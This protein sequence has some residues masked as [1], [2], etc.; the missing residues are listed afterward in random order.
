MAWFLRHWTA[1]LV[2]VVLAAWA[3]LY[4]PGTP[5]YA[6]FQ[7]KQ[8]IDARDGSRAVRFINF[9]KVVRS[10]A[11]EIVAQ[12]VGHNDPLG[13]VIGNGAAQLFSSPAAELARSWAEREVDQGARRVQMPATALVAALVLLHREGDQA[14]TR[15]RDRQGRLW[16]IRMA[17]NAQGR[18]QVVEVKNVQQLLASLQG[19]PNS[20]ASASP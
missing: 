10:A 7:L 1:T 18:W 3:L 9:P 13:S 6:V 15:F 8:A 20:A 17:R 14:S 12:Q 4:V 16:D 2:V 5:S 19:A 11:A